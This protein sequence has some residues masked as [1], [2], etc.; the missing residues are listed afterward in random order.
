ME[1]AASHEHDAHLDELARVA[2]QTVRLGVDDDELRR[3]QPL[4][5]QF[6]AN[7][8]TPRSGRDASGVAATAPKIGVLDPHRKGYPSRME[9]TRES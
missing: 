6:Q 1:L 9:A 5:K 4:L 2:A 8:D 3:R 7:G